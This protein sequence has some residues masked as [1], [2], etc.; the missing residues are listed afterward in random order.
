[1][2]P[3]VVQYGDGRD[4][5]ATA[6]PSEVSSPADSDRVT[7]TRTGSGDALAEP[8][9]PHEPAAGERL[10]APL[11]YRDPARYQI[12]AEHGRGGLGRVFRARDKELG[13]DVAVKELL[14]RGSTSE[15]RFFRE[16]LIT[17]RL[18][19]PG[20]VPVHEAGRWPD[21]TPFY[22]MK[23]VAGRPL[24]ALIDECKTI[25][26]RLALLPHVIAVADAIAY[27][28]DRKIIHRDL[29]PSNIIVGDFGET[30]VIDWGLAKDI[31]DQAPVADAVEDGPYRT[32]ATIAG[33]GVTVAGSIVG[34]PAYMSPEQALG[35]AV[36]ERADVYAIGSILYELCA[37][38]PPRDDARAA[39]K[40]RRVPPDLAVIVSRAVDVLEARYPSAGELA[41]DLHFFDT[42]HRIR[43]RKYSALG[44]VALW[45]RRN[46]G[47]AVTLAAALVAGAI[48]GSL[49]VSEILDQRNRAT[50]A[51][52]L[53]RSAQASS[54]QSARVAR[55]ERDNS[56]LA[57][58]KPVL[59]T[60]PP[61]GPPLR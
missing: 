55:L 41:N 58:A 14:S 4:A 31:S 2:F 18:E 16:A 25:E 33:D 12:V 20:I 5:T 51:L 24:K 60:Q 38:T 22:A 59:L 36:D 48:L 26:D 37:G 61:S 23:L 7:R 19:H 27:A 47:V 21:G 39:R 44:V 17:A 29:K 54:E 43:S 13:R 8:R 11:Q 32:A 35:E 40:L 34:T 53:T 6:A 50:S 45:A 10:P 42:G 30:V 52:S 15:L 9:E 56:P 46:R 1:M 49:S 28:H 3:R 57:R